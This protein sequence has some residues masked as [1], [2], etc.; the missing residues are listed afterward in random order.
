MD[1]GV[2]YRSRIS[3]RTGRKGEESE[4]GKCCFLPNLQIPN[5]ALG[6]KELLRDDGR[7][8]R[9]EIGRDKIVLPVADKTVASELSVG[10]A[11][12][13]NKFHPIASQIQAYNLPTVQ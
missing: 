8:D 6:V 12:A 7:S 13:L 2:S 11:L 5:A 10:L 9:K 1:E 4:T 3:R